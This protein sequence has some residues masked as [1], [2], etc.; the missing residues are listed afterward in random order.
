MSEPK[1]AASLSA[2][3]LARKGGARPALRPGLSLASSRL[4]VDKPEPVP[5]SGVPDRIDVNVA[6]DAFAQ[7]PAA[8]AKKGARKAGKAAQA[9]STDRQISAKPPLGQFKSMP[10]AGAK[11]RKAAFTL[12]LD[13][14]RHLKLRLVSAHRNESA[15]AVVVA[16]LD[17]YLAELAPEL[18]AAACLCRDIKTAETQDQ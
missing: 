6:A 8:R 17:R 1:P 18:P 4:V 14:D 2:N 11:E 9:S 3:L 15:Q 7:A 13:S 10:S 12:R 5:A 16:A